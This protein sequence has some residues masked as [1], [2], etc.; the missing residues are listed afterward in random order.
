MILPFNS[1]NLEKNV[2]EATDYNLDASKIVGFKF[3]N[4][5]DN[6]LMLALSWE[7][8]LSE[9]NIN[10]F[11]RRLKE[12]VRF[13][14]IKGTPKAL[15]TALSWYGLNDIRIEEDG[16]G[17]HFAEFQVGLKGIPNDMDVQNIIKSAE[18]SKP[19]RS[20]LSRMYN[21]EY[22]VRQLILDQS[23]FGY[24]LSGCSGIRLE[25][26]GPILSFGRQ[27]TFYLDIP[28]TEAL[29]FLNR[30]HF[31]NAKISR[32]FKL[33]GGTLDSTLWYFRLCNAKICRDHFLE[34]TK[35]LGSDKKVFFPDHFSKAGIILSHSKLGDVNT[36]F[37]SGYTETK[38]TGFRLGFDKLS[39]KRAFVNQVDI[40]ERFLRNSNYFAKNI[41]AH[42]ASSF[43]ER[44]FFKYANAE[45]ERKIISFRTREHILEPAVSSFSNSWHDHKHLDVAW[46]DQVGYTK[47]V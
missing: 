38:R 44:K 15:R 30:N 8:S 40:N 46:C 34:N 7:Y 28:K 9:I 21:D 41:F 33:S 3:K 45:N 5:N 13:F 37:S 10:D 11:A 23:P 6:W 47:F 43:F 1:T 14:R 25:E 16:K 19:L 2:S 35:K 12:G 20:R 39:G 18:K 24:C 32:G 17:A 4:T 29:G 27:N 36:C 31:K 42:T 22:D 26:G